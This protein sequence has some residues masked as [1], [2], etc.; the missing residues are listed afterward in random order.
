MI[1]AHPGGLVETAHAAARIATD[2]LGG[3]AK[4]VSDGVVDAAEA[5]AL[6]TRAAELRRAAAQLEGAVITAEARR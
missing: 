4:A 1:A 2:A 3:V 6:R 5:A